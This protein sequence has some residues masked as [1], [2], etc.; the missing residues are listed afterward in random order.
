MDKAGGGSPP[1][2]SACA[3]P[4][5]ALALLVAATAVPLAAQGTEA[6]TEH[7]RVVT[8]VSN[9]RFSI[10]VRE[11]PGS[12][13]KLHSPPRKWQR[14]PCTLKDIEVNV[15]YRPAANL[16][17]LNGELVAVVF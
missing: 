10:R 6:R 15:V 8:T 9:R 11:R 5:A 2:G 3:V 12:P 4:L 13:V 14:I 1:A 17:P 16:D 7:F